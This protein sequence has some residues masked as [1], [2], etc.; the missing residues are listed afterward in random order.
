MNNK[1][2]EVWGI[3]PLVYFKDTALSIKV[4]PA[5]AVGGL[6]KQKIDSA[7]IHPTFTRYQ[8]YQRHTTQVNKIK[9]YR[10]GEI[11]D[12]V[13]N[14][15][16]ETTHPLHRPEEKDYKSTTKAAIFT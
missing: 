5:I 8:K 15:T 6:K 1:C 11:K 3:Y 2:G 16:E 12:T 7:N 14:H 4:T 10:S 13:S 9:D